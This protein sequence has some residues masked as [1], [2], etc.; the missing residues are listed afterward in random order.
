V[1]SAHL[2]N[3]AQENHDRCEVLAHQRE[4]AVPEPRRAGAGAED[5]ATAAGDTDVVAVPLPDVGDFVEVRLMAADAHVLPPEPLALV[6]CSGRRIWIIAA[7]SVQ[8]L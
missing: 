1:P 2:L 7:A 8:A 3:P 5:R 4:A 6:N